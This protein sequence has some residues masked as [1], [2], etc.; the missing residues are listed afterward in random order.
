MS[1]LQPGVMVQFHLYEDESGLG[2]E[3][4]SIAIQSNKG[5]FSK[6]NRPQDTSGKNQ[7]KGSGLKGCGK[8]GPGKSVITGHTVGGNAG[9]GAENT[10]R[11]HG[12]EVVAG[13]QNGLRTGK[14]GQPKDVSSGQVSAKGVRKG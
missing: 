11:P 8:G 5:G 14:S 4:C 6:W 12:R 10:H 7:R 13:K 3:E 1:W 9:K 2:A